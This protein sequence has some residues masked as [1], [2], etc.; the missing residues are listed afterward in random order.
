MT[1]KSIV[2]DVKAYLAD[3][4][5]LRNLLYFRLGTPI[6][7]SVDSKT[8]TIAGS[9]NVTFTGVTSNAFTLVKSLSPFGL[10]LTNGV[11][12]LNLGVNTVFIITSNITSLSI[13]NA[14]T[15]PIEIDILHG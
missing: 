6:A 13:S 4:A 2:L 7:N 5:N 3:T 10:T 8:Q 1:L 11:G 14:S 12:T 9:S 15:S